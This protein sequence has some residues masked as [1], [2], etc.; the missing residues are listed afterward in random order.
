MPDFKLLLQVQFSKGYQNFVT[1][2]K[3]VHFPQPQ[4]LNCLDLIHQSQAER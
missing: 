2:S 3:R 1:M 4:G